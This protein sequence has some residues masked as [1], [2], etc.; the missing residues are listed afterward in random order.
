V[1]QEIE[2]RYLSKEL[3]AKEI[4]TTYKLSQTTV[5]NHIALFQLQGLRDKDIDE[6]LLKRIVMSPLDLNKISPQHQINAA[7]LLAK[8]QGKI[9]IE[10]A[11]AALPSPRQQTMNIFANIDTKTL[12]EAVYGN[13]TLQEQPQMTPIEEIAHTETFEETEGECVEEIETP[14]ESPINGQ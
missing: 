10:R 1:R 3:S 2:D 12:M 8:I 5:Y 7:A 4:A 11:P 13:H 6:D 9:G 14:L